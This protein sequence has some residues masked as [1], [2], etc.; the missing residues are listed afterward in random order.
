MLKTEKNDCEQAVVNRSVCNLPISHAEFLQMAVLAIELVVIFGIDKCRCIAEKSLVAFCTY[1]SYGCR[2]SG[3]S[4]RGYGCTTKCSGCSRRGYGCATKARTTGST[5]V[6]VDLSC[7][8]DAGLVSMIEQ[9][10]QY[11]AGDDV[12]CEGNEKI[13]WHTYW[14]CHLS[15]ALPSAL[16]EPVMEAICS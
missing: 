5:R 4:R 13:A 7:R 9:E 14:L 12:F 11:S 3:C 15:A 1:S 16:M 8:E 10:N 6:T 2:R